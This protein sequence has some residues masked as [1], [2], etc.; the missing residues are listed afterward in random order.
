MILRTK[1]KYFRIQHYFAL[2]CNLYGESLTDYRMHCNLKPKEGIQWLKR[3]VAKSCPQRSGLVSTTFSLGYVVVGKVW[4]CNRWRRV[5]HSPRIGNPAF[6]LVNFRCV[7]AV[8]CYYSGI[9][10]ILFHLFDIKKKFFSCR[11]R[12]TKYLFS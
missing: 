6:F 10:L 7:E 8:A 11:F 3:I 4:H 5:S 1:R 12:K 2:Y 9:K